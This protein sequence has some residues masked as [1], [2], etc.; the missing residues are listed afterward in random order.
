MLIT[1]IEIVVVAA[2]LV[3]ALAVASLWPVIILAVGVVCSDAWDART[4]G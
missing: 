4:E 3:L 2:L 1:I